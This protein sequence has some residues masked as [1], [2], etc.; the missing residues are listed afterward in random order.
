[1]QEPNLLALFLVQ[2][3]IILNILS[4]PKT[5]NIFFPLIC[6]PRD[7]C[8]FFK[9]T[10]G[11]KY[12]C[13]VF[14]SLLHVTDL[15]C[16]L[17]NYNSIIF[18]IKHTCSVIYHLAIKFPSHIFLSK[19]NNLFFLHWNREPGFHNLRMSSQLLA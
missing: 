15:K 3:I 19:F 8:I 12:F 10:Q 18:S 14:S 1:M 4:K 6:I 13:F 16:V 11:H 9:H 17:Y 7:Y 2:F 5:V